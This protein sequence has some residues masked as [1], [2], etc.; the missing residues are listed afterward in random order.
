MEL[1]ELV[2][3]NRPRHEARC[4]ETRDRADRLTAAL[5]TL[6]EEAMGTT[7]AQRAIDQARAILEAE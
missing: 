1:G 6:L 7:I 3:A 2:L 5:D 4:V